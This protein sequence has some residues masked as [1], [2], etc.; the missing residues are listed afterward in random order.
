MVKHSLLLL[1]CLASSLFAFQTTQQRFTLET[2]TY[3]QQTNGTWL[4]HDITRDPDT[5]PGTP[6]FLNRLLVKFPNQPNPWGL[7]I[8]NQQ[9]VRLDGHGVAAQGSYIGFGW[10]LLE[11]PSDSDGILAANLLASEH[12]EHAPIM[13][14][15]AQ[16]K[17]YASRDEAARQAGQNPC[18]SGNVTSL[19][20]TTSENGAQAAGTTNDTLYREQ[21]NL[22]NTS[23]NCS[24]FGDDTEYRVDVDIQALWNLTANSDRQTIVAV[25]D[26]GFFLEHEDL[27]GA[28][29]RNP[30]EIAGNGIDDDGNGFIDDINGFHFKRCS[31][32]ISTV[33]GDHGTAVA[34]IIAAR[35]GNGRGIAGITRQDN[36]HQSAVIMPI[37]MDQGDSGQAG[38]LAVH[39]QAVYYAVVNGADLINASGAFSMI[40][41]W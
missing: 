36:G 24:L 11:Y 13:Q 40:S 33:T 29:W 7:D 18:P 22:E 19:I 1:S 20:A 21:S 26:D 28:F 32:D 2:I 25:V 39:Y 8:C 4:A 3:T 12:T 5:T 37:N 35:T 9:T 10:S 23:G 14:F 15:D 6:V 16:V 17:H 31:G 30:G 41:Q 38:T 34:G 27:S